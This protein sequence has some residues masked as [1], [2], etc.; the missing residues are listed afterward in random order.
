MSRKQDVYDY[1]TAHDIPFQAYDHPATPTI[2]EAEKYWRQ[3][4]SMHCKN[5][6][7]RNKKGDRHYLVI[8]DC[9]KNLAIHDLEQ[10]LHQGQTDLR[11]RKTDGTLPGPA[12]RL[13]VAL[14]TDQRPGKPRVPLC[15]PEPARP[16]GLEL[17]PQRQHRH[18]RHPARRISCAISNSAATPTNLPTCT[19]Q[20]V[21]SFPYLFLK[22]DA[23]SARPAVKT[24]VFPLA[25]AAR[26]SLPLEVRNAVAYP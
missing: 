3:D 26:L 10:R 19:E 21:D 14:R 12:P 7:F 11:L 1:L 23:P 15:R 16:A 2:E 25:A 5:L 24:S 20:A 8:F 4:G 17:S 6:F 13:G 18:G 22:Q 9:A